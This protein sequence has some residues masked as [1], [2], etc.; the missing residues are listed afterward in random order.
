MKIKLRNSKAITLI[1]L[2]LS[3]IILL[4]IAG[5]SFN[6]IAGENGILVN[7]MKSKVATED[8]AVVEMVEM[9]TSLAPN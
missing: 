9:S 7:A 6:A 8:S 3:I 2:I 5:I 4:I 1:A